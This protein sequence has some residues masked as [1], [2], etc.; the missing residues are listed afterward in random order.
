MSQKRSSGALGFSFASCVALALSFGTVH[1]ANES[2]APPDL[3]G[4]WQLN[5]ARSEDP[6]KKLEE[7]MGERGGAGMP[8]GGMP[9]GGMPGGGMPGGGMP[10]GGMPGGGRPGGGMPGGTEMPRVDRV[11]RVFE[12]FRLEQLSD[13]IA[14]V[15]RDLRVR[16]LVVGAPKSLP[17]RSPA[18]IEQR[19][20]RWKKAQLLVDFRGPRE[21]RVQ[22]NWFLA[23]GGN[24]LHCVTKVSPNM[25]M[26]LEWTTVYSRIGSATTSQREVK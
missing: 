10:G 14:F 4:E 5:H 24:E 17:P 13:T 26:S 25:F 15:D 19:P 8:G 20:A 1:A 16:Q 18:G 7:K 11:S 22:E 3:R 9:G 23:T 21:E 12:R 2:A 6:Q